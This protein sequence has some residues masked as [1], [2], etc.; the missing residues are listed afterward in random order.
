MYFVLMASTRRFNFRFYLE[1]FDECPGPCCGTLT[2]EHYKFNEE[3]GLTIFMRARRL[4]IYGINNFR[5]SIRR[6]P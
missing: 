4:N 5:V 3:A 1:K 6:A 2:S